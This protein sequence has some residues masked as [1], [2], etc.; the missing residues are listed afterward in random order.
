[1]CFSESKYFSRFKR[2]LN[3]SFTEPDFPVLLSPGEPVP[4]RTGL[5]V[6]PVQGHHPGA[7]PAPSPRPEVGELWPV[8]QTQLASVFPWLTS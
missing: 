2:G 4:L 3:I 5:H 1:M 8:G 7:H 6:L